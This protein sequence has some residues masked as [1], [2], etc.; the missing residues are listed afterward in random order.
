MARPVEGLLVHNELQHRAHPVCDVG[1]NVNV[2]DNRV[3]LAL[4]VRAILVEYLIVL[5]E[6]AKTV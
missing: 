5:P 4:V 6:E 1:F 2:G 3:G